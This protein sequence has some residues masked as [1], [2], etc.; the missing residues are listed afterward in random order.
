MEPSFETRS[1]GTWTV[2]EVR[3]E[4]DLSTSDALRHALEEALK[5]GGQRV[6]ADLTEVTFMDSSSLGV[7]LACMKQA[8]EEEGGDIV[9]VGVQ[10][11]PAKVI[12]LTGL[13]SAFRM[14]SSVGDLPD[15]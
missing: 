8:R 15:D 10:G 12:A 7:L 1:A 3:G 2:V 14:E 4:L 13:D 11:S 9:L 6:A 5:V